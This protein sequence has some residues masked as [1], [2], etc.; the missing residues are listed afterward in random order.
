MDIIVVSHRGGRTWRLS[1]SLLSLRLWLPL[2]ALVA[3]VSTLAFNS[4][5]WTRGAGSI[6]PEN[7]VTTWA[8]EVHAQREALQQARS[9][10]E[11]NASALARRIAQLQAHMLRLDAA[12]QRMTQ[13]AGLDG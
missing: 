10:A 13:V 9:Q 5:Y 1:L 2:I 11:E 7:L 4:G 3:T 8:Q 12:G 6:L